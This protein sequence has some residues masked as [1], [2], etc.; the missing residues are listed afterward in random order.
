MSVDLNVD[1]IAVSNI[2]ARGYRLESFTVPFDLKGKTSG[3]ISDIL[4]RKMSIIGTYCEKVKKC[5]VMEDLDTTGS[6][7]RNPSE[8]RDTNGISPYTRC[9]LSIQAKLGK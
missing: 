4:G 2:D 8:R 7:S 9:L 1:H 6:K 3:Q 5:L